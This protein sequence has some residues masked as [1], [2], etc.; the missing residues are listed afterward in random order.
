MPRLACLVW[1][2][3][4]LALGV[5]G[6]VPRYVEAVPNREWAQY[7]AISA[8][9]GYL[10]G[11]LPINVVHNIVYILLGTGGMLSAAT[12]GMAEA[13]ARAL[14]MLMVLFVALGISPDPISRVG[15]LMPLFDWNVMLHLLA[16]VIMW[17]AGMIYPLTPHPQ[18]VLEAR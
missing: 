8:G 11:W 10:F 2:L 13:Y 15:G 4:F 7:I 16:G 14:F 5:C 12:R 17:Y 18:T 3:I 6:F 1:G 9:Y